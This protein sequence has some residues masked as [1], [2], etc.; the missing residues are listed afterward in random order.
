MVPTLLMYS[1]PTM[2]WGR[3]GLYN[4]PGEDLAR[5]LL[6][7]SRLVFLHWCGAEGALESHGEGVEEL[8]C[9]EVS[10]SFIAG[11]TGALETRS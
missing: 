11:W 9:F 8:V 4:S 1:L 6:W 2:M 3:G 10:E 7:A 5:V